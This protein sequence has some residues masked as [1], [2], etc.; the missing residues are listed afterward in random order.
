MASSG[1]LKPQEKG[2]IN[3]SVNTKGKSGMLSKAVQVYSNDPNQPVTTLSVVMAVK[4]PHLK[5]FRLPQGH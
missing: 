1:R 3:V 4:N 5:N 2:R